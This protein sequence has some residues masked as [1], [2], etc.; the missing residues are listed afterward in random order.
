MNMLKYPN[1]PI[2]FN[3]MAKPVG[4]LCNLDCN[5]CYYRGKMCTYDNN[6]YMMK[7]EVLES[8]VKQYIQ[9]QASPVVVFSWQGGEPTLAGP[10]FYEQALYFQKKYA[11]NKKIE[12]TIQ[13]NATLLDESWCRFLKR[14][15]FLVGIS[16]D[17]PKEIHDYHRRGVGQSSSWEKVMRGISLLRDHGVPFNTLTAITR[18]SARFP[19]GIYTFL[20]GLGSAYQQYAPVVER[21]LRHKTTI[22]PELSPPEVRLGAALTTWSVPAGMYGDFM[23]SIFDEWVRHDVGKVFVQLFETTLASWLGEDP[24]LCLFRKYCGNALVMEQNGDIYACDHFVF[25]RYLNGNIMKTPL[26]Q[27]VLSAEQIRFGLNKYDDL[28]SMCRSC[29]Y[30]FACHGECPKNRISTTPEG[31]YGLNYLCPGLKRYFQHVA[32]FMYHMA[33]QVRQGRSIVSVQEFARK[34][35]SME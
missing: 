4:A 1:I 15:K 17:G 28:P 22:E 20:K 14:H 27:L 12:N 30:L 35:L 25:P 34:Q 2:S 31:E 7:E 16:I 24:G 11:G 32:P 26:Q 3:L 9:S 8:Y 10:A 33:A 21:Y 23:V 29:E 13:T 18:H 5:Y 19:L 6:P